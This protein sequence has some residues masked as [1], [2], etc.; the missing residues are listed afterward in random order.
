MCVASLFTSSPESSL[1]DE[2]LVG[3]PM[4]PKSRRSGKPL[5]LPLPLVKHS[6]SEKKRVVRFNTCVEAFIDM[7]SVSFSLSPYL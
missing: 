4:S 1:S 7:L 3:T 5:S 2:E 6:I